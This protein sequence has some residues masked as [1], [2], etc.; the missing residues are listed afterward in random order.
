MSIALTLSFEETT[1]A[2][3]GNVALSLLMYFTYCQVW[4]VLGIRSLLLPFEGHK[5]KP[6]WTKTPRVRLDTH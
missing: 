2:T 4:I 1:E 5:G 6:F 3:L